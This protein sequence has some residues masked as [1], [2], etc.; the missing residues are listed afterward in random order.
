[1]KSQILRQADSEF[2]AFFSPLLVLCAPIWSHL[3]IHLYASDTSFRNKVLLNHMQIVFGSP[4]S[5]HYF[6]LFF[7]HKHTKGCTTLL[8][9]GQAL[10]C[11][12][13]LL[14]TIPLHVIHPPPQILNGVCELPKLPVSSIGGH[15][16]WKAW[17][18]FSLPEQLHVLCSH[19]SWQKVVPKFVSRLDTEILRGETWPLLSP[20]FLCYLVFLGSVS[21]WGMS[22]YCIYLSW[23]FK[24]LFI[25][26]QNLIMKIF[27]NSPKNFVGPN[28][29]SWLLH[30]IVLKCYFKRLHASIFISF[31]FNFLDCVI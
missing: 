14:P 21:L 1:M 4:T 26:M 25:C 15:L 5:H 24:M 9:V 30:Y 22:E 8:N 18:S 27:Y 12:P 10:R 3:W 29:L 13:G 2:T 28:F 20:Y 19:S 11:F 31:F 6:P 17:T 7:H 23:F 16:L